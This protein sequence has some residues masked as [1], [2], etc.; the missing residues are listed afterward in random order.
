MGVLRGGGRGG[1]KLNDVL[2]WPAGQAQ[3]FASFGLCVGLWGLQMCVTAA[4]AEIYFIQ[5]LYQ[6]F[7]LH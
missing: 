7:Q 4:W 1:H 5:L 3:F 2:G 6:I